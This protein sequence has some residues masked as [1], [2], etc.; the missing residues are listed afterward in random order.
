M[1]WVGMLDFSKIDMISGLTE[2]EIQQLLDENIDI[3][4]IE[5]I[6]GTPSNGTSA[7]TST[8]RF[9]TPITEKE[10]VKECQAS[11]PANTLRRNKWVVNLFEKWYNERPCVENDDRKYFPK[12][13][14]KTEHLSK[15]QLSY[16]IPKFIFEVR[17]TDGSMYTQGTLVSIISGIQSH[18][19]V[20][21]IYLN[22]FRD[23]QF[24]SITKS[25]DAAMKRSVSNNIGIKRKST[26]I[27]TAS[28]EERLWQGKE[29]GNETPLQ[30]LQTLFYLNGLHFGLRGGEEHRSLS[31]EQFAIITETDEPDHL[32]YT[33]KV[34][35]TY[36]GGLS[37]KNAYPSV[38]RYYANVDVPENRC[39]VRLFKK[40]MTLRPKTSK[41][42]YLLPKKSIKL[43]EEEWYHDRPI[44]HNTLR[45]ML[46]KMCERVG[47]KGHKTNHSLRATLATR[48]HNAN[49]DE[50]V[51]MEMTGHK[52]VQGIRQYKRTS[53]LQIQE[54]S[55]NIDVQNAKR[56]REQQDSNKKPVIFEFHNCSVQICNN[57]IEK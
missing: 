42:F 26:E 27:I 29:L 41:E 57:M 18:L 28:E 40:F 44:G 32:I 15:E 5:N 48:L 50:Q 45:T 8:S 31:I 23:S 21:G 17:K 43:G 53:A 51:S 56:I 3:E 20:Q 7:S 9:A 49:V 6:N 55:V 33:E 19:S 1:S 36:R 30:L 22:F 11:V 35:K 54:A 24:S 47:L 37:Q 4:N 52:S 25:L 34:G 38:K 39:H 13:N 16:L 46:S 10:L 12:P 2:E 14:T